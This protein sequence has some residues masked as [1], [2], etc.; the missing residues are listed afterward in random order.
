[1]VDNSATSSWRFHS[2]K[3]SVHGVRDGFST[4]VIHAA[5][6]IVSCNNYVRVVL[7]HWIIEIHRELSRVH[8][9]VRSR[10]FCGGV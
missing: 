6:I 7:F 2:Q 5:D 10:D 3:A 9:T 8:W 1:V 4:V